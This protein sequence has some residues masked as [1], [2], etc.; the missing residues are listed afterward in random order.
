MQ[1]ERGKRLV[2][3]NTHT[4]SYSLNQPSQST[5]CLPGRGAGDPA[6]TDK[7]LPLGHG[8]FKYKSYRKQ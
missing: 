5:C 4:Q 3:M 7:F 2:A 8:Q 6:V 1:I